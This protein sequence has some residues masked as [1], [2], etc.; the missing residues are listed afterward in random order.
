MQAKEFET[1]YLAVTKDQYELILDLDNSVKAL[2]KRWYVSTSFIYN[3]INRGW[4]VYGRNLKF[5]RVQIP[6]DKV[7]REYSKLSRK[8]KKSN[9]LKTLRENNNLTLSQMKVLLNKNKNFKF[10]I[11]TDSVEKYEHLTARLL[12]KKVVSIYAKIFDIDEQDLRS[13]LVTLKN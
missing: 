11:T 1:L 3:S 4:V 13:K 2:A 5:E 8:F 12:P 9:Y 6:I 10:R 7:E